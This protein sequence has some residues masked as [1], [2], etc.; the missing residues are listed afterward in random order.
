MILF[1]P[2]VII[3]SRVDSISFNF[4]TDQKFNVKLFFMIP[5]ANIIDGHLPKY[6]IQVAFY[7]LYIRRF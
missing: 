1:S 7:H 4:G 6:R 2:F 3:R 5:V